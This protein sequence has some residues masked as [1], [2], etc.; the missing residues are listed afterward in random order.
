MQQITKA[1]QGDKYKECKRTNYGNNQANRESLMNTPLNLFPFFH[2]LTIALFLGCAQRDNQFDPLSQLYVGSPPKLVTTCNLEPSMVLKS[3]SKYDYVVRPGAIVSFKVDCYDTETKESL[4]ISLKVIHSNIVTNTSD[5]ISKLDGLK[6][7]LGDSGKVEVVFSSIDQNDLKAELTYT[8]LIKLNIKPFIQVFEPK[9][10][11]E[12]IVWV[13]KKSYVDFRTEILDPDSLL[14]SIIYLLAPDSIPDSVLY[15]HPT[16]KSDRKVVNS[17]SLYVDT[18]SFECY[19]DTAVDAHVLVFIRDKLG[20]TDSTSSLIYFNPVDLSKRPEIK[21]INYEKFGKD[22]NIVC[23]SP[24]VSVFNGDLDNALYTYDLG[25]GVKLSSNDRFQTYKFT[26]PGTYTVKL[27]VMDD[28]GASDTSSVKVEIQPPQT[29]KPIKINKLTS[30][31]DSGNMPLK[32]SFQIDLPQDVDPKDV[33]ISWKF[34]DG[35]SSSGKL[36]EENTY[37]IQG[38]Y[39]VRAVLSSIGG[40]DTAYDTISVYPKYIRYTPFGGSVKVGWIVRFWL[41]NYNQPLTKQLRWTISDS[42]AVTNVQDTLEIPIRHKG[43]FEARVETVPDSGN[44]PF[45]P[46]SIESIFINATSIQ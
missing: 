41:E 21:K 9:V 4:P 38:K 43:P 3:E 12:N 46:I 5:D 20:R 31:I 32:V 17:A 23:F 19:S 15:I 1:T 35:R 29:T 26:Q 6:I 2:L 33:S 7:P 37:Y 14:D 10:V 42:V 25:N 16:S 27:T 13:G 45:P 22:S 24:E 28:G 40:N 39:I 11:R 36:K 30:T 34:G 18:V 44:V 8:F